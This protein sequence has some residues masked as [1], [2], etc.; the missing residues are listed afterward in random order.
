MENG[1]LKVLDLKSG[2]LVKSI[3]AHQGGVNTLETDF[4]PSGYRIFSGGND[5]C[6]KVWDVRKYEC[7]EQL[8]VLNNITYY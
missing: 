6:V 4:I 8:Q 5:G 2:S 1:S 7:L 3:N